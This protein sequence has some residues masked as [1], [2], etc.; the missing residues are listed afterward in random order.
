MHTMSQSAAA[1]RAL[2]LQ[3]EPHYP[4]PAAATLAGLGEAELQAWIAAGEV[5]AVDTRDGLRVPWPE[6]V[7]LA[8]EVIGQEAIEG[9][10]GPDLGR[11]M[12]EL[13]RLAELR[14]RIPRYEIAA[15]EQIAERSGTSVDDVV[16]W[17]LLDPAWANAEWI[18]TVVPSFA[19]ALR[20]PEG[21]MGRSIVPISGE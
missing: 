12:P 11:A 15:V 8:M 10:L 6:L 16:A 21:R 19:E 2:F 7:F 18:D 9:A 13:V 3:P 14:V 1:I 4:V 17:E 20:W 5:E